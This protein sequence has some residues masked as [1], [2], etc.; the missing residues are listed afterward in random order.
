[1]KSLATN[2]EDEGIVMDEDEEDDLAKGAALPRAFGPE[3]PPHMR[4]QYGSWDFAAL[5]GTPNDRADSD[6][7]MLLENMGDNAYGRNEDDDAGS[8]TAEIDVDQ[9][10]RF[11]EDMHMPALVDNENWNDT[12]GG[13]VLGEPEWEY[14]DNHAMYSDAHGHEAL[15]LPDAGGIGEEEENDPPVTDI[16]LDESEEPLAKMD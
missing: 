11:E 7:E 3:R 14:E 10:D 15:H 16:K 4:Q 5:D 12:E 9:D 13:F 8:T 2:S 1:M 6:A